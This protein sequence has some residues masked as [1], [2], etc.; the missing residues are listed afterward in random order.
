M[1]KPGSNQLSLTTA[2]ILGQPPGQCQKQP[3]Y[4][5]VYLINQCLTQ[6]IVAS[7]KMFLEICQYQISLSHQ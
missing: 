6:A 2:S 1:K 7:R 5:S 3:L 4:N